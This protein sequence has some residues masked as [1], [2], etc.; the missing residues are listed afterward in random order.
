[1]A[2]PIV[3]NSWCS[4]V[5]TEV[6]VVCEGAEVTTLF[7]S[8]HEAVDVLEKSIVRVKKQSRCSTQQRRVQ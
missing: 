5:L 2:R 7:Q 3:Y 8:L 4:C 1:M 6:T